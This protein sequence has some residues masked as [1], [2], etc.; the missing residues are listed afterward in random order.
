MRSENLT[1][2]QKAHLR[3]IGQRL[4]T[5]LSV[6]RGGVTKAVL[7]EVDRLLAG[8]ELVKVRILA[9]RE[10]RTAVSEALAASTHSEVVGSVGKTVLLY[11]AA[12]NLGASRIH[13][14]SA[15][16]A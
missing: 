2:H 12:P 7:H 14:P 10:D 16:A 4:E 13:L 3:G 11:R 15:P 8:H 5:G 9:D 6:G 1:G